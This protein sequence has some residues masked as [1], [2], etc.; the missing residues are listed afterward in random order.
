MK[1]HRKGIITVKTESPEIRLRLQLE[2][3]IISDPT[4]QR[5]I[6]YARAAIMALHKDLLNKLGGKRR[7]RKIIKS[8]R[9]KTSKRV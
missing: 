2:P 5:N 9:R 3:T 7:T 1:Y 4:A 6:K 8:K